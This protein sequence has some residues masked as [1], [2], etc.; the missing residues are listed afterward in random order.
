MQASCA[1]LPAR[2]LAPHALQCAAALRHA[3]RHT[4]A[5][6]NRARDLHTQVGMLALK[7]A[8][9]FRLL[10]C[11]GAAVYVYVAASPLQLTRARDTVAR[12]PDGPLVFERV[13]CSSDA[14]LNTHTLDAEQLQEEELPFDSDDNDI[15]HVFVPAPASVAAP[16][17]ESVFCWRIGIHNEKYSLQQFLDGFTALM[18]A[19]EEAKATHPYKPVPVAPKEERYVQI[20]IYLRRT[21]YILLFLLFA[22]LLPQRVAYSRHRDDCASRGRCQVVPD[23]PER[24]KQS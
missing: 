17:V 6:T 18:A 2:V 5:W 14:A 9:Q 1:R 20:R 16:E 3:E 11:R 19:L 10:P 13:L 15:P 23:A 22:C 24:L 7:Y 21:I 8:G 4:P 12:Q